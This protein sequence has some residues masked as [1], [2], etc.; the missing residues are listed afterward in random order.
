MHL[1]HTACDLNR[2]IE[3][4][5]F[6]YTFFSGAA[7]DNIAPWVTSGYFAVQSACP[8]FSKADMCG[9]NIDVRFGSKAEVRALHFYV[10]FTPESGHLAAR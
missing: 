3:H 9:A 2:L 10:R 4:S 8:L 5:A 1:S 7:A 6:V